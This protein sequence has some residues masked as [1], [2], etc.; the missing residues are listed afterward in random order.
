MTSSIVG[1]L[2]VTGPTAHR[3]VCFSRRWPVS[4][5]S[6]RAGPSAAPWTRFSAIDCSLESVA[7]YGESTDPA[8][9]REYG[10]KRKDGCWLWVDQVDELGLS[11]RAFAEKRAWAPVGGKIVGHTSTIVLG[12]ALQSTFTFRL[13]P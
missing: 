11:A 10:K 12:L 1:K 7:L 2:L 13:V 5:P 6:P 3:A 8:K 9:S 4:G